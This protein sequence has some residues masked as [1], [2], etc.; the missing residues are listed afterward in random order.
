M[1]TPVPTPKAIKDLLEGLLGRDITVS[2]SAPLSHESKAPCTIGTYVD[3]HL[4]VVGVAVADLPFSAYA[5]A[6]LGLMPSGGAEDAIEDND[7]FDTLRDNMYEVL[8]IA[9]SLLNTPGAPHA[10]LHDV[11]YAGDSIPGPVAAQSAVLG[12]REDL[13]VDIAGYGTGR[14]S[15]VLLP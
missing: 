5:G 3:D 6:A 12:C 13:T 8:N 9:A 2:P 4:R 10:K 7:L 11:A 15:F 14:F 1:S